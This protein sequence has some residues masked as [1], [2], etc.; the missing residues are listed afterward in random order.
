MH[1]VQ[2]RFAGLMSAEATTLAL[3]WRI[4]RRDGV[5]L[6]FTAHD[7]ALEIEGLRYR[8]APGVSPSAISAEDGLDPHTMELEGAL[9]HRAIT[10]GDLDAGRY[11]GAEVETFMVDWAEPTAGR[12]TLASGRLGEVRHSGTA[13]TA[14]L[15]GPTAALQASPI[16][17]F[18][19]E[20]R[21][22]FGDRRC[23]ADLALYTIVRAVKDVFTPV[24]FGFEPDIGDLEGFRYGRL[25]VLT[26]AAAGETRVIEGPVASGLLVS[27]PI[28]GLIAGNKV[29]LRAGCDKRFAT[30]RD[31]FRNV[32]NFR[33]EPH[34]PGADAVMRY[35]G[36]D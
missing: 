14:E 13:F 1:S 25:R 12:I 4:V 11:D 33:G 9:S 24:E 28:A 34:V 27:A 2:P 21:A 30:C 5:A 7:R 29:E 16:E 26:G 22:T 20:C 3:C 8:S 18:S 31:R 10:A 19:P 36:L 17:L 32:L 35:P 6:G 15:Q 23:R